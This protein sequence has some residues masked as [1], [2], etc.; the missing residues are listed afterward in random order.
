VH[1]AI[2]N[3]YFEQ[4]SEFNRTVIGYE[5]PLKVTK[6]PADVKELSLIQLREEIDELEE[7]TTATDEIDALLDLMYFANGALYKMGITPPIFGSA[8]TIVHQANMTKAAGKKAAR[9]YSGSAVDAVKPAD[10]VPPEGLIAVLIN[11]EEF[12]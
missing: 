7:S 6:L 2:K 5:A 4:V 3:T 1:M 12:K 11:D 10:F 8:A 9:G